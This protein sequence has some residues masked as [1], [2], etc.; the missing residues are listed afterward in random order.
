MFKKLISNL[1]FQPSLLGEVA[2]YANRLKKETA[3]RRLGLLL[4]LVGFGLQIFTIA[5]PPQASLATSTNDIVYGANSKKDILKAFRNNQDQIG[6]KDIKKI[7]LHYGIG[8]SQILGAKKTIV[9]D[10]NDKYINTSRGTTKW[11]DTFVPIKGAIDGGIY[12]FPLKYW[13][14]N[15]YPNG[16]PAITG[17]S[18]YGFKFWILLKGCGNI[19][20]E[21]GAKKPK[22]EI[23]KK[24][25][26]SYSV[27]EG[28][29]TT[30]KVRFR[31]TGAITAKGTTI[32]DNLP[33]GLEYKSYTSN[34]DLKFSRSGQKLT[35]K[36]KGKNN[37]LQS[38]SKWYKITIK[39]VATKGTS[40][41][42]CNT[43][44]INASNAR[45]ASAK[46]KDNCIKV[47]EQKCPG[48]GLPIPPGGIGSCVIRCPDG[49]ELPYNQTCPIPQLTCSDLKVIANGIWSERTFMATV[50]KQPGATV[51]DVSFIINGTVASAVN[52]ST[53][54]TYNY[55]HTFSKAGE[56]T[57][58]AK[59]AAANGQVQESQ[60]CTVVENISEPDI[61]EAIIVTDKKVSNET[62]K[63]DDANNTTADAGDLLNYSLFISNEGNA[64]EQNLELTGEYAED[65]SDILEY[66]DVVDL[67]DGVLNKSTGKISWAAVTIEPGQTIAKYFS[68]KVKDPLPK[69]PVSISNPLSYDF[70][71]H[72][73]YGR[74]VVVN[75][76]KPASKQVEEAVTVLPNTGPAATVLMMS[77]LVVIVSYF[78]YRSRLLSKELAIIQK[79][80]QAGGI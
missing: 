43:A 17:V 13:N 68:V 28:D 46:E 60:S 74:T 24:R 25:T 41:K 20:F 23:T 49:S 33:K 70:S 2:F 15:E 51:K 48:T 66:S 18:T 61:T 38:G 6:R 64:T 44:F 14:K 4:I 52:E 35:W 71:M 69:T 5:F 22:L 63:I 73:E 50:T 42:R 47:V 21:K 37:A 36:V 45:K 53:G 78:Y 75:L 77:A 40:A 7:F 34:I 72:N 12:E 67:G 79:E 32:V 55:S 31:N 80:F 26:S 76:K 10:S 62:Q 30:F 59:V 57:I 27:S 19:V 58:R 8:E 3:V 29:V 54:N 65:I 11:A 9:K 16:Y 1:P 39:T 56:Y